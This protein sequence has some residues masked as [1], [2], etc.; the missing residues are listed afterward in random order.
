MKNM[1]RQE[2]EKHVREEEIINAAEKI[3]ILKGFD[4]ASMDE[5]A[6][7]A[8]FTKRTLYRYFESKEDLFFS[9]VIKGFKRLYSYLEKACD[10]KQN[11]YERIIHSCRSYYQFYKDN[12]ELLRLMNFLGYVKAKSQDSNTRH[13]FIQI[14]SQLFKMVTRIIEDGK[15]DGSINSD[16]DAEKTA[17]SLAFMMT[18]FLNQLSITGGS[19]TENFSMDIEDF[20]LY[21][22]DL[23]LGTLETKSH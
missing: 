2:R 18:G 1:S 14:N 3:F 6:K 7:E 12:P 16:L 20:S 19:F 17:Y 9:V 13:E 8:E 23:L 10:I 21:T 22:I 4:E 11:G 15:V 5:I